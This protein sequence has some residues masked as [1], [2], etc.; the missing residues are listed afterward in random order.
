[1]INCCCCCFW[2]L[3]SGTRSPLLVTEEE[4]DI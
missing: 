1:L 2:D 4:E 3:E